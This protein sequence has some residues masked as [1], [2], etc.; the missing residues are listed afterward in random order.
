V[1]KMDCIQKIEKSMLSAGETSMLAVPADGDDSS[2]ASSAS[3]REAEV[4]ENKLAL[5]RLVEEEELLE[6][7]LLEHG[8]VGLVVEVCHPE[9]AVMEPGGEEDEEGENDEKEDEEDDDD[10]DEWAVPMESEQMRKAR[11]LHV[12]KCMSI[13]DEAFNQREPLSGVLVEVNKK[14]EMFLVYRAAGK[15]LG[16]KKVVFDDAIGVEVFGLWYAP[17]TMEDAPNPPVSIKAI[18]SQSTTATMAIPLRY[19]VG[20]EHVHRNKYCVITNWWRERVGD[21]TYW[22][23]NLAFDYYENRATTTV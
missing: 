5:P 3:S 18:S 9:Q 14:P 22:F 15:Q 17:I 11:T 7:E 6:E 1:Y 16:W 23:P 10:E 13:L 21:G 20:P 2:R 8:P 19:A 12:Y 4:P